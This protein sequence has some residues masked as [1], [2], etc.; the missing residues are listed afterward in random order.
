MHLEEEILQLLVRIQAMD[1]FQVMEPEHRWA[2]HMSDPQKEFLYLD[3]ALDSYKADAANLSCTL[4]KETS[5]L[6]M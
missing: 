3:S 2:V 6:S 5:V 1:C 4:Q